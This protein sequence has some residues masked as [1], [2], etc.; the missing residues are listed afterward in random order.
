[1]SCCFRNDGWQ[2]NLFVVKSVADADNRLQVNVRVQAFKRTEH[3][4]VI[5]IGFGKHAVGLHQDRRFVFATTSEEIVKIN[6]TMQKH[7]FDNDVHAR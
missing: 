7:L 4:D 2:L 1:M 3:G 5:G 6:R